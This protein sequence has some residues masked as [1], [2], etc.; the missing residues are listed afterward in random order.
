LKA[1]HGNLNP[2]GFDYELWLWE[3]GVM[4][5][6]TVRA[7]KRD[8]TPLKLG[9]SWRYAIAQARQ[10]VRTRIARSSTGWTLPIWQGQVSDIAGVIA[11]LVM[12][13]QAAISPATWDVFRVT[14]VAHLMSISGLHITLFAWLM[15]KFI[16]AGWLWTARHGVRWCLWVPAPYAAAVGGA[17]LATLYALF[18]G[19]GLPAQRTV[20]MLLVASLLRNAGFEWPKFWIL[21]A[22][23]GVVVL[24]DPWALM[25]AGFWLSFVAVGVLMGIG[26]SDPLECTNIEDGGPETVRD[27]PLE[28]WHRSLLK[29]W[30]HTLVALLKEQWVLSLAL[31]PLSILFF[32]QISGLGFLANLV[33]IPW[34]TWV[35]TPLAMLGVM[36]APL[37]WLAACAMQ[38]LMAWHSATSLLACW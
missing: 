19:W 27:A 11:A 30:R 26:P 24:W 3:Q 4:A 22:A 34:V 35:V 10:A 37:W 20:I 6:G 28:K 23:L 12:G 7:G 29:R 14:G 1:P 31:T 9:A 13:D 36:W 33:A 17:G 25:Q 38:P 32:G 5:T 8:A 2:Q 21:G 18:S 15:A 16:G